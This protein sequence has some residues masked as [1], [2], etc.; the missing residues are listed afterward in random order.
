MAKKINYLENGFA[1]WFDQLRVVIAHRPDPPSRP[2]GR[3]TGRRDKAASK[4]NGHP[5]RA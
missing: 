5:P 1:N 3:S 2:G 4:R